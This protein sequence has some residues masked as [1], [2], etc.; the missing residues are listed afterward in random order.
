MLCSPSNG[1]GAGDGD[2]DGGGGG[3]DDDH[4]DKHCVNVPAYRDAI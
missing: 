4:C 3:G 2:N 1:D